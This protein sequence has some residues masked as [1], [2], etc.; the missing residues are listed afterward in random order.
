MC[1]AVEPIN[2]HASQHPGDETPENITASDAVNAIG[3]AQRREAR[4]GMRIGD[5]CRRFRS[6]KAIDDGGV[7]RVIEQ[8]SVMLV[9]GA[10]WRQG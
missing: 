9:G 8:E 4:E 3:L 7:R 1:G 10:M 2:K 5:G 6:R